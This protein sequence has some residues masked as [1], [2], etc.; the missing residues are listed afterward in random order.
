MSSI[1]L[2][3]ISRVLL[4]LFATT[5]LLASFASAQNL[6]VGFGENAKGALGDG[7]LLVRNQS[8]LLNGAGVL[9]NSIISDI[10]AGGD[11]S[12]VVLNNG[13]AYSFGDNS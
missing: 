7:T 10:A 9:Q 4:V 5:A 1:S 2:N 6:L 3:H 12:I 8:V 11:H 13:S